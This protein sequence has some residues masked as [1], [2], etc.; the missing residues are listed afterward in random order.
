MCTRWLMLFAVV[1]AMVAGPAVSSAHEGHDHDKEMSEA[2]MMKAWQEA[3]TPGAMHEH[4]AKMAGDWNFVITS[5]D[6][7]NP[8]KSEGTCTKTMIMGGRYIQEK[9]EGTMM[10]MPFHGMGITGFDTVTQ[11]YQ[12]VWMDN[13]STALTIATGDMPKAGEPL[14]MTSDFVDPMTKKKSKAR[15]VYSLVDDDKHTFHWYQK[16]DGKEQLVMDITYTRK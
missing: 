15:W 5:H 2:E 10:G 4:L 1:V 11:K 7:N 8:M 16:M 3:M 13:M 14:V 6:P 12:S 9:S